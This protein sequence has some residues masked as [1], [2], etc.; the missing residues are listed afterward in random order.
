[1]KNLVILLS[2]FASAPAFATPYCG[3]NNNRGREITKKVC[4][5]FDRDGKFLLTA[6]TQNGVVVLKETAVMKKERHSGMLSMQYQM[7]QIDADGNIIGRARYIVDISS[8]KGVP[9]MCNN[10]VDR[11][12][13]LLGSFWVGFGE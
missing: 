12:K 8:E 13:R 7:A 1:M 5:D 4:V 3:I 11:N 6:T 9:F 2:L 10:A